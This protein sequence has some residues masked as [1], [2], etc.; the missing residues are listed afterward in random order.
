MRASDHG[1]QVL[2]CAGAA[3]LTLTAGCTGSR[4]VSPPVSPASHFSAL[5]PAYISGTTK[6][7]TIL[8]PVTGNGSKTFTV[9]VRPS[10]ILL[11]GCL[12]KGGF[13]V[14]TSPML[15]LDTEMPCGGNGRVSGWQFDVTNTSAVHEATVLVTASRTAKWEIRIDAAPKAS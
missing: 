14:V 12:G 10:Y 5:L 11:L 6:Y 4:S 3:V 1:K 9:P 15:D 8:G 7:A 13:A 2:A